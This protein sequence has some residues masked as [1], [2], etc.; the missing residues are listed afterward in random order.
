MIRRVPTTFHRATVAL[1][2]RF[3]WC[4]SGTPIQNS[5]NDL[6]ALLAFTQIKPFDNISVFRS[7]IANP[8][9]DRTRKQQG[10]DRLTLLLEALCLRRTIDNVDVP[11]QIERVV[12]VDFS[13]E[14]RTQY[15]EIK[16]AMY[17]SLTQQANERWNPKSISGMFQ[18]YLRL[19]I[20]CNH[21]SYQHRFA[22]TK[23]DLLDAEED[24]ICTL[25]RDSFNRC[26]AC[27]EPLPV[28]FRDRRLRY[29]E[30][31]NHV[32]CRSCVEDTTKQSVSNKLQ[33]CPLCEPA[34]GPPIPLWIDRQSSL[35]RSE[36]SSKTK[37]TDYFRRTGRSSKAEA[38]VSDVQTNLESTKRYELPIRL[39][40]KY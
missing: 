28:L 34:G 7:F 13:A 6:G 21:G 3:R 2:A 33:H 30:R 31:C 17:K 1:V 11:G 10:I 40:D 37:A 26:S 14:E 39:Q 32:L 20:L 9:E 29:V 27:R 22:W 15:E 35:F 18:I 12:D 16:Q 4:L 24:A 36:L 23:N 19:R 8:F 25:T 5:L 38:L